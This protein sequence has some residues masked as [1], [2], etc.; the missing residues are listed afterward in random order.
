VAQIAAERQ[1]AGAPSPGPV[2]DSQ[3]VV[4]RSPWQI[5]WRRFRSDRVAV[6]GGI[7]IVLLILMAIAAPLISKLTG[8]G[9]NQL[10][11]YKVLNDY[12]LP[13]G[14]NAQFWFGADASGR[15]MFVR[16]VYGARTS[17]IVAFIATGIAMGLGV[18]FGVLAGYYRGKVDTVISRA[19]DVVLSLP[20]LLLALGLVS[21]CGLSNQGCLG[22]LIK[23]GLLLVSYVI[24]LF[25]WPYIARIVRGQVL[26]LR[27]KEFI[28]AARAQGSSNTRIMLREVLPNIVAPIIVY[29]TLIVPNNV[30]FEATL[31]FLGIG[32]PPSTPS[33]GSELS[34]ASTI[35][36][37][38]WWTMLFPGVFLFATT[39]AF[40][41]VGD[42]L[43]DALDPRGGIR[44]YKAKKERG[45]K[46]GGASGAG[47]RDREEIDGEGRTEKEGS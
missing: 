3:R 21:A 2:G 42:G 26:S 22:G 25:S 38:A 36:T 6:A 17:L 9:P 40:N 27:E 32:V 37:V 45:R 35:F 10:F 1:E 4:G 13:K 5:F 46:A 23:P 19:I 41:L 28:E 11:I 7:F 24:G 33:W 34:D 20:V 44:T 15:D 47:D 14:P 18:L 39:L 29:S 12:G 43:R 8:H 16:V 30:L 31:S